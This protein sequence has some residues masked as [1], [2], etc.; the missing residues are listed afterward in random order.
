MNRCIPV[1]AVL[2]VVI[3]T[4]LFACFHSDGSDASDETVTIKG[5]VTDSSS[6]ALTGVVVKITSGTTTY[7]GTVSE[8]TFTVSDI[9]ASDEFASPTITFYCSG[10]AVSTAY[11]TYYINSENG[12]YTLNLDAV[13]PSVSAGIK[14]YDFTDHAVVMAP[15]TFSA[16]LM[17]EDSSGN[18][19][20]SDFS[21]TLSNSTIGY[22]E[23]STTD[24]HGLFIFHP[25]TPY[26]LKLIANTTD[27]GY[28]FLGGLYFAKEISDDVVLFNLKGSNPDLGIPAYEI[29]S[30]V[31]E[32]VK[33]YALDTDY[34]FLVGYSTGIIKV[35]V[36]DASG[37]T[38]QGV[39]VR[40]N[41]SNSSQKYIEDTDE[42]GVAEFSNIKIGKYDVTVKVGGFEEYNT[43]VDISKGTNPPISMNL[44]SRAEQDFFG[45]NFSH[46]MMI[47]GVAIGLI[48]VVLS[49]LMYSGRLKPR[50][51]ED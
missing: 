50:L 41:S 9:P 16:Y 34:P 5:T 12:G 7:T 19:P 1:A 2:T 36:T 42:N 45:M 46:F 43:Q 27:Q 18:L 21:V 31:E 51:E 32:G 17:I 22:S 23:T 20:L 11:P 26:N 37:N 8:T 47:L 29:A 24:A 4:A 35:T 30:T 33:K 6:E 49:F 3:F 10:M 28:S 15:M 14:T 44:S 25:P 39:S 48:L 40:L 38:L 13:V